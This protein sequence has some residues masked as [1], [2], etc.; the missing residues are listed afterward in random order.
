MNKCSSLNIK[1]LHYVDRPPQ[2]V[3]DS[4][5]FFFA[6]YLLGFWRTCFSVW[7]VLWKVLQQQLLLSFTAL[8][9]PSFRRHKGLSQSIYQS[10]SICILLFIST[11]SLCKITSISSA[12]TRLTL[13]NLTDWHVLARSLVLSQQCCFVSPKQRGLSCM[14]RMSESFLPALGDVLD[15]TRRWA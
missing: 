3:K 7:L 15:L 8:E 9:R 1:K 12:I 14:S 13:S 5:K 10:Q 6:V 4:W 2:M 11:P